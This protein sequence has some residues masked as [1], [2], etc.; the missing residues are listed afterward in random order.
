MGIREPRKYRVHI[1]PA[2]NWIQDPM[3]F[4][5][6]VNGSGRSL[7]S[8]PVTG[9]TGAF[10]HDGQVVYIGTAPGKWDVGVLRVR[11]YSSGTLYVSENEIEWS[12]SLYVTA[13]LLF[14][15]LPRMQTVQ[16]VSGTPI[17]WKDTDISFNELTHLPPKANL[18]I[19]RHSCDVSD[20]VQVS[21]SGIPMYPGRSIA[22]I[23]T[24]VIAPGGSYTPAGG[25]YRLL[26]NRLYW[27]RAHVTDSASITR[28]TVQPVF[29]GTAGQY[30]AEVE[31]LSGDNSG[32]E[33]SL[34]IP[35]VWP[36]TPPEIPPYA[37]CVFSS[38]DLEFYGWVAEETTNIDW[39]AQ[40]LTTSFFSP[41]KML[42]MLR[43][44]AFII[45]DSATPTS[46]YN[47][48]N[49]TVARATHFFLEWH[50]TLN[51]VAAVTYGIHAERA[52]KAQSFNE[53]DCFRQ[54][55]GDLVENAC[56]IF[57]ETPGNGIA[58]IRPARYL[59]QPERN[60]LQDTTLECS[61]VELSTRP[62]VGLVRGGGFVW[63][64][65]LLSRYPGSCPAELSSTIRFD[66][67]IVT[68]QQELNFLTGMEFSARNG[69]EIHAVL[70]SEGIGLVPGSAWIT[71]DG[72]RSELDRVEYTF[73]YGAVV[74]N[75][76]G[77][78]ET[79]ILVGETET[80]PPEPQPD[81][82]SPPPLPPPPTIPPLPPPS[83]PGT[84]TARMKAVIFWGGKYLAL[85]RNIR[86][87]TPT[88]YATELPSDSYFKA[89]AVTYD[90]RRIRLWAIVYNALHAQDELW[91]TDNIQ[92]LLSG[93]SPTWV[94]PSGDRGLTVARAITESGSS[95]INRFESLVVVPGQPH[96]VLVGFG[97]GAT[98]MGTL[99]MMAYTA[100]SGQS[101]TY[102]WWQPHHWYTPT[103]YLFRV[104]NI[105]Q[106]YIQTTAYVW[107]ERWRKMDVMG[108]GIIGYSEALDKTVTVSFCKAWQTGTAGNVAFR[109]GHFYTSTNANPIYCQKMTFSGGQPDIQLET[110]LTGHNEWTN[111]CVGLAM[112]YDKPQEM[113]A[114]R[115]NATTKFVDVMFTP[116]SGQTW[117]QRSYLTGLDFDLE[118]QQSPWARLVGWQG[119]FQEFLIYSLHNDVLINQQPT[120][121][122]LYYSHDG[123]LTWYNKMGN[124]YSVTRWRSDPEHRKGIVV[125]PR[126]LWNR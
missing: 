31:R 33:L 34:R 29:C 104:P 2:G 102:Y 5:A 22:T 17:V 32:W 50:T 99:A 47:V 36:D 94:E 43:G 96:R 97:H 9:I 78:V 18:S 24:S 46:W 118:V 11:G 121:R 7:M 109:A 106:V 80:V 122:R 40:I 79:N 123:G 38:G 14:T 64:T 63:D 75:V 108:G 111:H 49:M 70:K 125:I 105:N 6:Q 68:G 95:T 25:G 37:L 82:G 77:L 98:S 110:L 119:N 51:Q 55:Y 103:A 35:F 20:V 115:R 39:Q 87:S 4:R 101:W 48:K 74:C 56:C 54:V 67:R 66:N 88:W 53:G 44:L 69:T 61:S 72:I 23:V 30:L 10:P 86:A 65:P 13:P 19:S 116:D 15:V 71:L 57:S 124:F 42:S 3:T 58:V 76:S 117:L 85:C 100:N 1:W 52:V 8:V 120:G 26:Q 93:N 84:A 28:W 41:L 12:P 27:V 92:A 113:M 59:T 16:D 114:I 90:S 73:Q 83:P 62:T 45:E 126:I 89:V 21:A 60:A 81:P 91:Y 112:R 107:T